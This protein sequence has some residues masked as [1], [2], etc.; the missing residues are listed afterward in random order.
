MGLVKRGQAWCRVFAIGLNFP[1]ID[2]GDT[3]EQK[4]RAVLN[5]ALLARAS[6]FF[7]EGGA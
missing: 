7:K 2:S 4:S 6:F 5:P 1:Q 3:V